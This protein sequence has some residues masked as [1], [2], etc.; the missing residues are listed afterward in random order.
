MFLQLMRYYLALQRQLS[1]DDAEETHSEVQVPL[2][3]FSLCPVLKALFYKT[4]GISTGL[5]SI[6]IDLLNI[7]QDQNDQFV[8]L[9]SGEPRGLF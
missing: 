7:P 8:N 3:L 4:Q 1:A 6:F 9:F 5:Q 2:Q